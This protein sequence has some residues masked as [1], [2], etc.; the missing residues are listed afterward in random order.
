MQDVLRGP[1]ANAFIQAAARFALGEGGPALLDI[2]SGA[3]T[4]RQRESDVVT[5]LPFLWRPDRHM[6]LKPVVTKDFAQRVGHRLA[7]DYEREAR[8]PS[9][10]EP[11]QSR[12]ANGCRTCRPSSRATGINMQRFIWVVGGYSAESDVRTVVE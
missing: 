11:A 9:L 2:E 5:Y 8:P 12:G 1:N 6:F 3:E 4:T 7:L 10:R